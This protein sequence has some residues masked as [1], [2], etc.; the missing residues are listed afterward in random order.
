MSNFVD[1]HQHLVYGVDDGAQSFAEMQEMLRTAVSE[2]VSDVVCTS[3]ATPGVY[4]FPADDYLRHVEKARMWCQEEGLPIRLHTGCE[5]LYTDASA[6]LA[7]EGHFPTLAGTWNLLVEFSPDAEYKR[8]CEAARQLGNAGFTVLYAHVERY[9]A[10]HSLKRVQ[11]LREEYG[12]LMQ[13]NTH[14]VTARK[15]FFADRWVRHM[16]ENGYIDCVGTDAHNTSSR[17]CR[18]QQCH[19]AL[20]AKYGQEY[21]DELCGGFARRFLGL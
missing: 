12:V 19:E 4:R 16:L 21:A 7:R 6:R 20:T 5:V 1:I 17:P 10:L 13:M 3:H 11:E 9:Q 14:T 18:M 15:G 2:G 8:L